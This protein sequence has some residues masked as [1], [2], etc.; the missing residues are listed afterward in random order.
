MLLICLMNYSLFSSLYI[1]IIP[2]IQGKNQFSEAF[3]KL[4]LYGKVWKLE[5]PP[6]SREAMQFYN[7]SNSFFFVSNSS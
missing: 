1:N 7:L 2:E 4:D 5:K 6:H 3:L